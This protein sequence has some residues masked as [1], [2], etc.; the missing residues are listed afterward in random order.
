MQRIY[1]GSEWIFSGLAPLTFGS[2]FESINSKSKRNEQRK[3]FLQG[4]EKNKQTKILK[5]YSV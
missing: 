3:D 5:R 4:S 2:V 1:V